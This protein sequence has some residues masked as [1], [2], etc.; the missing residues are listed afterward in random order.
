MPKRSGRVK[1]P[2]G[3]LAQL[4]SIVNMARVYGVR[5]DVAW[6]M[7]E[8]VGLR[9]ELYRLVNGLLNDAAPPLS[10]ET[11]RDAF[12]RHGWVKVQMLLFHAVL[13]YD[14][15]SLPGL[16]CQGALRESLLFAHHGFTI[17]RCLYGGHWF[18]SGDPRRLECPDHALAGQQKRTR[19]K[20][21]RA[22]GKTR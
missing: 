7:L 13:T 22:L 2:A 5:G 18:V 15:S 12:D 19:A 21:R 6:R 4:E 14:R 8:I 17:R 1:R 20:H 16:A 3:S 9:G 11:L 10:T